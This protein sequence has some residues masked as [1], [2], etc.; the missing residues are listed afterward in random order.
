MMI[1]MID[2]ESRMFVNWSISNALR[3]NRYT[4]S[5]TEDV[6]ATSVFCAM[7]P[8]ELASLLRYDQ[9]HH[10]NLGSITIWECRL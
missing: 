10:G 9:L 1:T 2:V 3:E 4:Q 7:T 8:R 5:F 6:Q